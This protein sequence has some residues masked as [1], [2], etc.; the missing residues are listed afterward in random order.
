[1][2]RSGS[3]RADLARSP[4]CRRG[5][6]DHFDALDVA[7]ESCVSRSIASVLVVDQQYA[8][9]PSPDL[10]PEELSFRRR[11]K[12]IA[13]SS[14][15]QPRRCAFDAPGCEIVATK[16]PPAGPAVSEARWPNTAWRRRR[17]LSMPTPAPALKRQTV[18]PPPGNWRRRRRRGRRAG[19]LAALDTGRPR[20]GPRPA[21]LPGAHVTRLSLN[22][23]PPTGNRE[24]YV[25]P[26]LPEPLLT[27]PT[28][29]G[30]PTGRQR[31]D[32]DAARPGDPAP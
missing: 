2:T 9:L 19:G 3:Q 6:A 8:H 25:G 13:P 4:R 11:R 24:T 7:E 15:R 28:C 5:P 20:R 14:Y 29:R 16:R 32:R 30:D 21:G 26:W 12:S 27:P 31:L 23:L 10:L 18:A 22:R 1:M 17:T